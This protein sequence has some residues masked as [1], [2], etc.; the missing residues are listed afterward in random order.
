M[1]DLDFEKLKRAVYRL[2]GVISVDEIMRNKE[3]VASFA[4]LERILKTSR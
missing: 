3:L 2:M 4:R 1:E